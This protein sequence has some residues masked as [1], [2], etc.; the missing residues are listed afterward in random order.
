MK[1]STNNRI[2]LIRA[3]F[4]PPSSIEV[5]FADGHSWTRS[6]EELELDMTS[7]K[8][9]TIKASVSGDCMEVTSAGNKLVQIDSSALRAT[10]DPAYKDKLDKALVALRGPLEDLIVTAPKSQKR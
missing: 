3:T 5:A 7:M 1:P 6:F 8:L 10:V 4:L 2:R 9:K